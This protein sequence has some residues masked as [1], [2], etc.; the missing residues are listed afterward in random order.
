MVAQTASI[1]YLY[2][3][4]ALWAYGPTCDGEIEL[5]GEMPQIGNGNFRVLM[6]GSQ[7]QIAA[8]F[9]SDAPA[10]L[11]IPVGVPTLPG[12]RLLLSPVFMFS[13]V[14]ANVGPAGDARFNLPI[15]NSPA[16]IGARIAMQSLN[17]AS[18]RLVTTNGGYTLV[19]P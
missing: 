1:D 8:L 7:A 5:A 18:G 2:S 3:L 10:D 16:L 13:A 4:Y 11:P 12:C 6:K 15:P 17:L 14:T 19:Q 9:F